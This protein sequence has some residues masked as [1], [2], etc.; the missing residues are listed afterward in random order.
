MTTQDFVQTVFNKIQNLFPIAS[1]EY[2]YKTHSSTHFIKVSP[3]YLFDTD[4]FLKLEIAVTD[5]FEAMKADEIF[6]FITR[7]SLVEIDEPSLIASSKLYSLNAEILEESLF[8]KPIYTDYQEPKFE[9]VLAK[10]AGNRQYAM[11]A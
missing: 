3:S 2:Q 4:E 9:F 6:C 10:N 1:L 8:D 7:E 5:K 11:A